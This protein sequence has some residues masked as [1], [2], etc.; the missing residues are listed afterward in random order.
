MSTARAA[1][2]TLQRK[3]ALRA[4]HRYL[5]ELRP[6]TLRDLL[7]IPIYRQ[8]FKSVPDM[9]SVEVKHPWHLWARKADN[10]GWSSRACPDYATAYSI[11]RALYPQ[12]DKYDDLCIVSRSVLF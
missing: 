2:T 10:S 12:T 5:D 9:P 1:P 8:Y 6:P 3:V 7:T 11:V 4:R